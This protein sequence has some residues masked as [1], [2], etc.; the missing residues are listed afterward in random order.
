[1]ISFITG[2]IIDKQNQK[3]T[4]LTAGGVGYELSL[5][6][7][8]YLG[9]E[10]NQAV[11][12]YTYLSVRENAQ[13]LFG[14][15]EL[16]EKDLFMKFLEVNGVGPKTAL[17]LLSLGTV[18]EISGAIGRGDVEYLTKI[19]GV[20]KKTAER[21][22]VE[23]KSKVQSLKS[24]V[25]GDENGTTMGEVID[26]LVSLGYSKDEARQVVKSLDAKDKTSE[27][28]LKEALKGMR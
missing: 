14:F 11:S 8:A 12:L 25:D 22:V 26:A 16:A 1:M 5:A 10:M 19:S 2:K 9:L 13:D 7:M 21:I 20:G 6:P 3:I 27:Q 17:H 18:A 28:L 23:L 15:Q 24:K 4:V